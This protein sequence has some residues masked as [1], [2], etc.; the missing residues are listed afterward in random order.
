MVL[1]EDNHLL[2]INKPV[3][4]PSQGDETGDLNA[5]DWAKEY[6]R[7]KY[8]KPGNVYMGLVHRLDRPASG[9]LVLAKTSK[10]AAR[11]SKQFQD[12]KPQK[13]YWVLTERI[14]DQPHGELKHFL[15][16]LPNKNIMRAYNKE[17]HASKQAHLEYRVLQTAGKR[18]LLEVQLHTGRR[19]QIRVQLASM[20]CTIVGD[21]KYG[22]TAFNP[23][24]S[25]CLLAREIT[26]A[27]PTLKTPVR[28]TAPMPE[29][30]AWKDFI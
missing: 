1:F 25:I 18:A 3:G 6:V 24:K 10:A 14:P 9:V 2:I 19:H 29:V 4:M 13:I 12:K 20:G 27:H 28:V 16:K 23:D 8:N 21:V 30:H 17:V 15:K 7:E 22:K 26:L 5:F 11:L